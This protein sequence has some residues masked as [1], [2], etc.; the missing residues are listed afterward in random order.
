MLAG[1]HTICF[2]LLLTFGCLRRYCFSSIPYYKKSSIGTCS[3]VQSVC[4]HLVVKETGARYAHAHLSDLVNVLIVLKL[5][6]LLP[7][8]LF[9]I[10]LLNQNFGFEPG[11][12]SASLFSDLSGHSMN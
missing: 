9:C 12:F 2:R 10:T 7:L 6:V 8:V 11:K 5:S 3:E 4:S 1:M